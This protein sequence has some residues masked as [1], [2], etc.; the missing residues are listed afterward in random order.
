MGT[1]RLGPS[2]PSAI[3]DENGDPIP[4]GSVLTYAGPDTPL[5]WTPQPS[6]QTVLDLDFAALP[7]QTSLADGALTIGGFA[8]EKLGTAKQQ[9]TILDAG[10]LS[11]VGLMLPPSTAATIDIDD[12]NRPTIL[13]R[14]SQFTGFTLQTPVR[15]TFISSTNQNA[16]NDV[17]H[18]L[19]LGYGT[20][21][22]T[23]QRNEFGITKL[24]TNNPAVDYQVSSWNRANTQQGGNFNT[25][26]TPNVIAL[27]TFQITATDGL[28]AG[29]AIVKASTDTAP[30]GSA[31]TT[32]GTVT[33]YGI[34]LG[35]VSSL[36]SLG[37]GLG[38]MEAVNAYVALAFWR[39]GAAVS[40]P[41]IRALKI[42]LFK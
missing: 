35:S 36:V 31:L 18:A 28:L 1:L 10:I 3:F 11:G 34:D 29:S 26:T 16:A 4:P 9:A 32:I 21:S 12:W 24:L 42:E 25:I 30:W 23:I 2:G 20:T 7:S 15:V 14:L 8:F 38:T 37:S 6:W 19:A 41:T 39:N 22:G 40:C 27:H 5:V 17:G 13:T 33:G